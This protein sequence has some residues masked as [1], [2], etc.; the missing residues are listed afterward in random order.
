MRAPRAPLSRREYEARAGPNLSRE[1][2]YKPTV[3][4]VTIGGRPA[5]VKDF[6]PRP[7][8]VR[9]TLGRISMEREVRIYL[10]LRG[11]EGVPRFLGVLDPYAFAVE[12]IEGR[13]VAAFKKG[14]LPPGFFPALDRLLG[15][16]HARGVVHADLRQRRNVLVGDDGRP[17]LIDFASGLRL[18][19]ESAWFR[20]ARAF[21]LSGVAKL[22]AKH[23]P[24]RLSEGERRLLALERYRL[25]R[26]RRKSRRERRRRARRAAR[27]E[28]R[29][30]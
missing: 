5:L 30:Q 12:R 17:F 10:A 27:S 11:I 19:R 26:N 3:R 9:F 15:E 1:C 14:T 29:L 20:M 18:P 13:D 25:F 8:F 6:L 23:A 4:P 2:W 28:R 22:K 16:I 24:D 21:D 7:F